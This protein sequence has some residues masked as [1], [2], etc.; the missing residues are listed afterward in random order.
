MVLPPCSGVYFVL[1]LIVEPK[2]AAVKQEEAVF[3]AAAG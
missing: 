3:F 2:E 1:M